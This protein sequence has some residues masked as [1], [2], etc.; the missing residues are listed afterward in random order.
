LIN[1]YINKFFIMYNKDR[2]R[3][4]INPR[5]KG[6][7]MS[8]PSPESLNG[9]REKLEP[10]FTVI[11]TGFAAPKAEESTVSFANR[12]HHFE[13]GQEIPNGG[14]I[15]T[16]LVQRLMTAI[17]SNGKLREVQ[18][19]L[20]KNPNAEI[21]L[22]KGAITIAGKHTIKLSD[23]S[24]ISAICQDIIKHV[25]AAKE[26][27]TTGSI[28]F[29][30]P[31]VDDIAQARMPRAGR[32]SSPYTAVDS[33]TKPPRSINPGRVWA[34]NKDGTITEPDL[35]GKNPYKFVLGG[36]FSW[37]KFK[38]EKDEDK[39]RNTE[40]TKLFKSSLGKI[41][42]KLEVEKNG[43][44]KVVTTAMRNEE[45]GKLVSLEDVL[46]EAQIVLKKG[47]LTKTLKEESP[48]VQAKFK[49]DLK[50]MVSLLE[51]AHITQN[52]VHEILID[53]KDS[54]N[55]INFVEQ[56]L[57]E[58]GYT[59]LT[60][61]KPGNKVNCVV[62]KPGDPP[63]TITLEDLRKELL[64]RKSEMIDGVPQPIDNAPAN[65]LL[66][67]L[68][69]AT[70]LTGPKDAEFTFKDA[71]L[72]DLVKSGALGDPSKL[73]VQ[74]TGE[75]TYKVFKVEDSKA[76]SL[77]ELRKMCYATSKAASSGA[78][79][80]EAAGKLLAKLRLADSTEE[81]DPQIEVRKADEEELDSQE[82][83]LQDMIV[84]FF[85][86]DSSG[87][88]RLVVQK[89][90]V[91]ATKEALKKVYGGGSPILKITRPD[92]TPV[93]LEEI[94]NLT[95]KEIK[96]INQQLQDAIIN[97]SDKPDDIAALQEKLETAKEIDKYL[98]N[99]NLHLSFGKKA[100]IKSG[101]GFS[102]VLLVVGAAIVIP[103]A[104]VAAAVI[105]AIT[106]PVTIPYGIWVAKNKICR[107]L[108]KPPST[109]EIRETVDKLISSI[110]NKEGESFESLY[111]AK[112]KEWGADSA[113][114]KMMNDRLKAS[115]GPI[116]CAM[117]RAKKVSEFSRATQAMSGKT[118]RT[119]DVE[120]A[121]LDLNF[122]L[123]KGLFKRTSPKVF[124]AFSNINYLTQAEKTEMLTKMFLTCRDPISITQIMDHC[125]KTNRK[126]LAKILIE[127]AVK[128]PQPD[129]SDLMAVNRMNVI[130]L[131][132][133]R[134]GTQFIA[135]IIFAT[136]PDLQTLYVDKKAFQ[137]KS[138]A[139]VAA[140]SKAD[141]KTYNDQLDLFAAALKPY[142]TPI[143]SSPWKPS[144]GMVASPPAEMRNG[145]TLLDIAVECRDT[146]FMD[147][148]AAVTDR[149]RKVEGAAIRD[150]LFVMDEGQVIG[151]PLLTRISTHFPGAKRECE[152]ITSKNIANSKKL[153]VLIEQ[154][155]NKSSYMV[156]NFQGRRP[157]DHMIMSS[158]NELDDLHDLHGKGSF[159]N[160]VAAIQAERHMPAILDNK[161]EYGTVAIIGKILGGL[162]SST[163]DTYFSTDA[164]KL[165]GAFIT[166]IAQTIAD[167]VL[168]N[169]PIFGGAAGLIGI[170]R[171]CQAYINAAEMERRGLEISLRQY[172]T[173]EKPTEAPAPS[174]PEKDLT[175]DHVLK[176]MN[177]NGQSINIKMVAEA[178]KKNM[179]MELSKNEMD[180][181]I[182]LILTRVHHF[183]A[184]EGNSQQQM[185]DFVFKNSKSS[186][187]IE[188]LFNGL[189]ERG[190]KGVDTVKA[191]IAERMQNKQP[192]T[193]A[194]YQAC[195]AIAVEKGDVELFNK[196][197]F[198][199]K[200]PPGCKAAA[201][202]FMKENGFLSFI[203]QKGDSIEHLAMQSN[204]PEMFLLVAL[205]INKISP[206]D[207]FR[208][209]D[210]SGKTVQELMNRDFANKLDELLDND[211]N[212]LGS[213]TDAV[214]SREFSHALDLLAEGDLIIPFKIALNLA[215]KGAI[216]SA[217]A[218]ALHTG[219]G[220][221]IVLGALTLVGTGV[222]VM[223][224]GTT[225]GYVTG[226]VT[227]AGMRAG[228]KALSGE[229][230]MLGQLGSSGAEVESA[231]NEALAKKDLVKAQFAYLSQPDKIKA[232]Q[233]E[234]VKD[235][236]IETIITTIK[237]KG[238]LDKD[239][240]VEVK[241]ALGKAFSVKKDLF[242]NLNDMAVMLKRRGD[243]ALPALDRLE[244]LSALKDEFA[245]PERVLA[246]RDAIPKLDIPTEVV[247]PS[248]PPLEAA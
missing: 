182:N 95:K 89:T 107:W 156:E 157:I 40:F 56:A 239:V 38:F 124:T 154:Q 71:E 21:Q 30:F 96:Q 41:G 220:A 61:S 153:R 57:G 18:E 114:M 3:S 44:Y 228:M 15:P 191:Y 76:F 166:M 28:T 174:L 215:V 149:V 17:T 190:P 126:D 122:I 59:V 7:I 147:L 108:N 208:L 102:A 232:I 98:D 52:V 45:A 172:E 125:I 87:E 197:L 200:T 178:L 14:K 226:N 83:N 181:F 188:R 205:E 22:E 237:K 36:K 165:G 186:D 187:Q 106:A 218:A 202:Q 234:I 29:T 212:R 90:G 117:N 231:L 185:L 236:L 69:K 99:C 129:P 51:K 150:A 196:L 216:L 66:K 206:T 2:Y 72:E 68:Y 91:T 112:E 176:A 240:E 42:Y 25:D 141:Q 180:V 65:E 37:K 31:K 5:N 133:A 217:V 163:I 238:K 183:P 119:K 20:R 241:A 245:K 189:M 13:V 210:K 142:L 192:M 53:Q 131:Q 12:A 229:G 213:F 10:G 118:T 130:K 225:G 94:R 100:G 23:H 33:A 88:D 179:N 78:P 50:K 243:L 55:F 82:R 75:D 136:H 184:D 203:S 46:S 97:H 132:A 207:T 230:E 74:K 101:L 221:G 151:E 121:I 49:A 204:S 73:H 35:Y 4:S 111:R 167:E 233:K 164:I 175:I 116:K 93:S 193:P 148:A 32:G 140:L 134:F 9:E 170:R 161:L 115:N 127:A 162:I 214:N 223:G 159:S 47:L 244:L 120:A 195:M 222:T 209:K 135:D 138:P 85:G 235:A 199:E 26:K 145:F 113:K 143:D 60:Q 34:V 173:G 103:V 19:E 109:P 67:I 70:N 171:Y 77:L 43:V 169:V 146:K 248:A 247:V 219:V 155:M 63:T 201:E 246:I 39:L 198:N 64:A 11:A 86:K 92:G 24:D 123:E 224:T 137:P 84:D 160:T 62:T 80:K 6:F 177:P 104:L 242:S 8:F 227:A 16:N 27:P 211:A 58:E 48:E 110:G 139:E 152:F 128:G 81:P 158:A 1:S 168:I 54:K 194:Q 144:K 105:G 79:E